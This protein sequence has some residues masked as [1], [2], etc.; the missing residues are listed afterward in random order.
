MPRLKVTEPRNSD[1]RLVRLLWQ[2]LIVGVLLCVFVPAARSYNPWF[3]WLWYWLI[4]APTIA[5]AARNY[6]RVLD[7]W[8]NGTRRPQLSARRNRSSKHTQARRESTPTRTRTQRWL[9]AG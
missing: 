1:P 4:A 6:T 5:L 8:R 3:G 7:T 2:W 9:Q